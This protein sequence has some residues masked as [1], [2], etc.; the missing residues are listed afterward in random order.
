[1][2]PALQWCQEAGM[3]DIIATLSLLA[4]F[5]L[6]IAYTHGADRLRDARLKGP[7]S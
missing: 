1:M 3:L 2:P 4:M 6:A 7:R 5:G